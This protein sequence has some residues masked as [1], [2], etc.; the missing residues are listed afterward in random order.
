M[1]TA[2]RGAHSD[3]KLLILNEWQAFDGSGAK[4][5]GIFECFASN[6]GQKKDCQVCWTYYEKSNTLQ[7]ERANGL[8]PLSTQV[9]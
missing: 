2:R 7:S 8:F 3:G 9:L 4:I 1:A 6:E 5:G